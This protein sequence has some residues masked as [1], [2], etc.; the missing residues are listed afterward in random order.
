[1]A[2]AH[3]D[4][5][6]EVKE[7]VMKVTIVYDNE[8]PPPFK[9]DWGFAC[10][11]ET[12]E[13]TL[14]FDTGAKGELLLENMEKLNVDPQKI[15]GVVLSHNHWDHTGGLEGL[16]KINSNLTVF[17][18]T[19][20]KEPKELFTNLTTTGT[21][22]GRYSIQEQALICSTKNGQV[23]ITG[24]SHPGLENFVDVAKRFGSI[25]V[26]I[27]GF[28]GFDRFDA[29]KGISII[30]P[31]HCTSH[32]PELQKLYPSAYMAGGVGKRLEFSD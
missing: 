28:H 9:S 1:L 24:C 16:L 30:M 20:S 3:I 23:L 26:V 8:A 32:K 29:L 6:E 13:T 12:K 11:V 4:K 27:G 14:L 25:H 7:K 17:K 31:C 19:Y 5:V 2:R 22:G 10:L 18:P 15:Q 21:L